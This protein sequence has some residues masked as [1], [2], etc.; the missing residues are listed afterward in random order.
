MICEPRIGRFPEY[1]AWRKPLSWIFGEKHNDQYYRVPEVG[2]VLADW[3]DESDTSWYKKTYELNW[4]NTYIYIYIH[5]YIYIYIYIYIQYQ[6]TWISSLPSFSVP[7]LSNGCPWVRCIRNFF[8][9]QDPVEKKVFIPFR[10]CRHP[11][12]LLFGTFLLFLGCW[13][14]WLPLR[15]AEVWYW[16]W[17]I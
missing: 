4:I 14:C 9:C 7:G 2:G 8:V 5:T 15:Y 3:L 10:R 16:R 1:R 6:S 17:K 12:Q 11:V 13:G